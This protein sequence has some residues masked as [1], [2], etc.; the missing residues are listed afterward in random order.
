MRPIRIRKRLDSQVVD[1]PELAPLVGKT[2]QITVVEEVPG[3][4]ASNY[5]RNR[6]IEELANEQ[7]IEGSATLEDLRGIWPEDQRDD[8][9]EQDLERLRSQPWRKDG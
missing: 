9:F 5:W 7:G 1:L 6:S 2:V 3:Q 4:P 8:D